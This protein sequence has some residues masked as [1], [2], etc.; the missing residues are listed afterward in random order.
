MPE[1]LSKP[2]RYNWMFSAIILGI[3]AI[4]I[5]RF[6]YPWLEYHQQ[7]VVLYDCRLQSESLPIGAKYPG[8]INEILVQIGQPINSGDVIARMD[9]SELDARLERA[10]ASIKLAQANAEAEQVAIE[11]A[12]A[13]IFAQKQCLDAKSKVASNRAKAAQIEI[14]WIEKQLQRAKV[15]SKQ[16][17]VSVVELERISREKD[18]VESKAQIASEEDLIARLDIAA[19]KSKVEEIQ[20]RKTKLA[21]FE[22]EIAIAKSELNTVEEQKRA[23]VIRAKADGVVTNIFRGA[24]ASV[25]IG[26]PII[27]IQSDD[28]WCEAWLD[29]AKLDFVNEGSKVSILL[30]AFNNKL[31]TGSVAGFL[32]TAD[33]LIRQ[34]QQSENP[35]LQPNSKVCVKIQLETFD[36][37]RLIPGMTGRAVISRSKDA[38]LSG[39]QRSRTTWIANR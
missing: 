38:L 39:N 19:L 14:K 11:K 8:R 15:L 23:S 13:T 12:L 3:A 5:Y 33:A 34:P 1:A 36:N 22:Q 29:E 6:G 32:P 31:L 17:S 18:A 24:G 27:Q 25:K 37:L 10:S 4:P 30:K 2:R 7:N 9:S 20:A 26:D 28:V 35:M 16:R 21:V